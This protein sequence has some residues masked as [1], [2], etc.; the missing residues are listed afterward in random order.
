MRNLLIATIGFL[1]G[2]GLIVALVLALPQP[3]S[4]TVRAAAATAVTPRTSQPATGMAGSTMAAS[5]PAAATSTSRLTIQHV[6][7]GCHVWSNGMTTATTMR[8]TLKQGGKLAIL[9]QDVDAHQ[10]VQLSGP[11]RLRVGGPMLMNHGTVVSFARKGLYRLRT[12]TVEMPG[13]TGMNGTGMKVKTIGPDN[14]LRLVV[15]VA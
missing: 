8:L 15:T 12:R 14:T 6:L 4:L 5:L 7:K 9:D 1:A 2:A 13:G 11:A 3:S 10:L